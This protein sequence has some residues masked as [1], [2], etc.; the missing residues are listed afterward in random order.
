MEHGKFQ[1]SEEYLKEGLYILDTLHSE[2]GLAHIY[3]DLAVLADSTNQ[4]NQMVIYAQKSYDLAK[5]QEARDVLMTSSDLLAKGLAAQG[6]YKEAFFYLEEAGRH[7]DLLFNER[8]D[9]ELYSLEIRQKDKE[10]ALANQQRVLEA[11]GNKQ[12]NI[13]IFSIG[14]ALL[15]MAVM[16]ALLFK[17]REKE[18]KGNSLLLQ[19]NEEIQHKTN[20]IHEIFKSLELKNEQITRSINAAKTIQQ[21][22]LPF[23]SRLKELLK[24]HFILYRPKDIVSGDFYWV[25]RVGNKTIVAV[26][27]CTGHGVPGAFMSMIGNTLLDEI[28]TIKKIIDPAAILEELNKQIIAS[29]RQEETRDLNGM[30]IAIACFEEEKNGEVAIEFAGAKR[31]LYYFSP[32]EKEIITVKGTTRHIGGRQITKR[33]FENKQLKLPAG[34]MIYLT[35]DGYEDQNNANRRKVGRIKFLE[36]LKRNAP[37]PVSIQ[38]NSLE[39]YLSKQTKGVEQRDDIMILGIRI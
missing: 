1:V 22:I 4:T 36:L 14:G 35:S 28:I 6:L 18:K 7:K 25:D 39:T 30:D 20:E 10:I 26:I 23:E 11:K 34:S 21:A 16:A 5:K 31:P 15:L 29:L 2:W 24:E 32:S 27:D 38:K 9:K 12:K 33:P 3:K 17:G 19:K 13:I 8:K 37:N